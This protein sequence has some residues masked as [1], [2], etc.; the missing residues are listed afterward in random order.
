MRV[1]GAARLPASKLRVRFARSRS[2]TQG[3]HLPVV[4]VPGSPLDVTDPV[5][6]EV[7]VEM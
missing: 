1:A 2:S 6:G 4:G 3:V 5:S 7:A